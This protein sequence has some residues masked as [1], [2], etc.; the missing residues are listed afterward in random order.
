MWDTCRELK[1][2]PTLHRGSRGKFLRISVSNFCYNHIGHFAAASE[3]V[4]KSIFLGGV[5]RRYPDLNFAFLEGGVG[6]AVLLYADLI[7]HWEICNREALEYTNPALLDLN[8]LHELAE[9]F[10]G[11]EM[12]DAL[13]EGKGISHRSDESTTGGLNDLDDYAVCE[14]SDVSDFKSLFAD[15]FYFG[16]EADDVI[17]ALAFNTNV[18]PFGAELKILFGSDIG[19]FDVQ[20]MLDVL[21]E[22]HELVDEGTITKEDFR[23][24]VCENPVRFW[25]ETNPEFFEGTRVAK[26]AQAILNE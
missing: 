11:K 18:N 12:Y 16:C 4:C 10:G 23:H 14:I 19:H 25:G 13:K 1:V 17:N 24:F 7:N 8:M 22:A 2:S 15:R 26:Q 20:D 3:A 21:P 5:T 9:Q 6:F